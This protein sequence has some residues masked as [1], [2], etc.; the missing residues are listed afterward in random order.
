MKLDN[1]KERI[2]LNNPRENGA[3]GLD[4]PWRFCAHELDSSQSKIFAL[5]IDTSLW[6]IFVLEFQLEEW[7]NEYSWN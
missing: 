6:K 4:N 5:E 3:Q 7:M 2:G 1:S